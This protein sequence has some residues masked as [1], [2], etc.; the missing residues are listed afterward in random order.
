MRGFLWTAG[1][2]L[3]LGAGLAICKNQAPWIEWAGG[4]V[5]V[6][7]GIGAVRV[8]QGSARA[9]AAAAQLQD[10]HDLVPEDRAREIIADIS[11]W[12][13][14]SQLQLIAMSAAGSAVQP[15]SDEIVLAG[16]FLVHSVL[17]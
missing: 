15:F 17:H 4:L 14:R 11:R 9:K 5:A 3:C 13:V 7:S 1:A 2:V 12:D 10:L 6:L 16:R 8:M